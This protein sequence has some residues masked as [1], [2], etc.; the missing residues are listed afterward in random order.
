MTIFTVTVKTVTDTEPGAFQNIQADVIIELE[1][2]GTDQEVYTVKCDDALA[3]YVESCL[4]ASP[5]VISYS[6]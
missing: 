6:R 2:A 4:D 1:E 3:G 5:G